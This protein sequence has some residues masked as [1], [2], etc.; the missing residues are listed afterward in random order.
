MK[1]QLFYYILAAVCTAT[2]LSCNKAPELDCIDPDGER[3]VFLTAEIGEYPDTRGVSISGEA[4]TCTWSLDDK[5]DLVYQDE[6][7]ATLTVSS[8]SNNRAYL[9]GKVRGAYPKNSQMT[10][11]Y[12]GV[13]HI[14][15]NQNGTVLSAAS[16]AY[17]SSPV[18]IV[19]QD[20]ATLTLGNVT[21]KHQQAYFELAFRYG[22]DLIPVRKLTVTGSSKFVRSRSVGEATIYYSGSSEDCFTVTTAVSDGLSALYFALSDET[23]AGTASAYSFEVTD[24]N[25]HVYTAHPKNMTGPIQNGRYYSGEWLLDKK[26][27]N[28]VTV[29]GPVVAEGLIY[30]AKAHDLITAGIM[31]DNVSGEA[32][33]GAEVQYFVRYAELNTVVDTTV[34][35]ADAVAG[36]NESGW[37]AV[38]PMGTEPG[39][40]YIYY[41]V[42]GGEYYEDI[43]PAAVAGNP[44]TIR[45]RTVAVT[46]PA[47]IGNLK[48]T[49][50]SQA[51]VNPGTVKDA[52]SEEFD[53]GLPL[54]YAVME[55]ENVPIFGA[56]ASSLTWSTEVPTAVNAGNY[57]IWYKV[58]GNAHYYGCDP[59]TNPITVTIATTDAVIANP[60]PIDNLVYN[61]SLQ[62]IVLPADASDGCTVYYYVT[63]SATD[64]PA[65]D[66]V[67]WVDPA[68]NADYSP[69]PKMKNA[70]T[71]YVWTKV[72]DNSGGDNYT[73]IT[74]VS[75]AAVVSSI[76]KADITVT[77]PTLAANSTYNADSHYLL[78]TLG[79]VTYKD[80]DNADANALVDNDYRAKLMYKVNSGDWVET[81]TNPYV[82]NA[83][84]YT[85]QYKVDGGRNFKSVNPVT[86][87]TVVVAKASPISPTPPS[88]SVFTPATAADGW[89]YDGLEHSL[90]ATEATVTGSGCVPRYLITSNST[91]PTVD[92]YGWASGLPKK[93]LP[94]T[95]YVWTEVHCYADP[96]NFYDE[97]YPTPCVVTISKGVTTVTIVNATK[98]FPYSGSAQTLVSADDYTV[99]RA[100]ND[101]VLTVQYA[102]GSSTTPPTS[103]WST[104]AP[105]ATNVADTPV[106]IWVKAVEN[107][108][109]QESVS[110][111][112]IT[113]SITPVTPV[114]SATL[115]DGWDFDNID[116]PLL[117]S[118]SISPN[119]GSLQ[120]NV[121]STDDPDDLDASA[122]STTI[123]QRA[124]AGTYYVFTRV[125][126]DGSNVLSVDPALVGYVVVEGVPPT[127]GTAPEPNVN[128]TY[129]G[130]DYPL[131]ISGG[132]TDDGTLTYKA[133]KSE[134]TP[135]TPGV[136]SGGW[137][138]FASLTATDAGTYYIYALITGDATH[139][140]AVFGPYGPVQIGKAAATLTCDSDPLSFTTSQG[141]G[142]TV[143]KSGVSCTGGTVT[144]SSGTEANCTVSYS[145]GVITVTRV[146]NSAFSNTVITVSVTPD[147]NHTWDEA[148][149]V[150][151]NVSAVLYSSLNGGNFSGFE[152][153]GSGNEQ[154]NW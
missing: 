124:A 153:D 123:P 150:T 50:S 131:L 67:G 105:A 89:N 126:G 68:V 108:Y 113:A 38:L 43:A 140:N 110:S 100:T 85:V 103:G 142:S 77:A 25:N 115:A 41:K 75:A 93:D 23:S 66:A 31:N 64:V 114:V 54:L 154:Y 136:T 65:E 138:P 8:I 111:I 152:H 86:L 147:A 137:V 61:G 90:I 81:P 51:L 94:G 72:V 112:C 1:R 24:I 26:T 62:Q 130:S 36:A 63:E 9:V 135:E 7:I 143:L 58:D 32:G 121:G 47:P 53:P 55:G 40:Y 10:L 82:Y 42:V 88:V 21:L 79:T 14:Y 132:S 71:Y 74:G 104:T 145:E 134:T 15:R 99:T 2:V 129:D 19:K 4:I 92:T 148:N 133:I 28:D 78:A 151:F 127:M 101:G 49:G 141:A 69:A 30:D 146:N 95:Y 70:G 39:D 35:D 122:W 34:P 27:E 12:G 107:Q 120:F 11:Y 46:E 106:Y 13:N 125:V 5:V 139:S 117:T 20:N 22:P 33:P 84:N 102:T 116:R 29:V 44:V 18:K 144:V 96:A 59:E 73:G 98:T 45:K 119:F 109:F 149:N 37:S 128:T 76:A 48:Y 118:A 16:R 87:G 60:V 91:A 56:V 80:A 52:T 3:D 6:V 83:G 57:Y 97:V 17:L